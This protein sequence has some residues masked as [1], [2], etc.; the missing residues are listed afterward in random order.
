[1]HPDNKAGAGCGG[2]RARGKRLHS[3]QASPRP[4]SPPSKRSTP[5]PWCGTCGGCSWVPAR[6]GRRRAT[7]SCCLG[8]LGVS[9]GRPGGRGRGPEHHLAAPLFS[10]HRA[11][12][13]VLLSRLLRGLGSRA[14][15]HTA[16]PALGPGPGS[17]APSLPRPGRACPPRAPLTP[18][19][20]PLRFPY[21]CFYFI[22]PSCNKGGGYPGRHPVSPA[23]PLCVLVPA[24]WFQGFHPRGA[25]GV[26]LPSRD[27]T[28]RKG[29]WRVPGLGGPA[30]LSPL[31]PRLFSASPV[32]SELTG[33]G[34][35][36]R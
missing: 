11:R 30:P 10:P 17:L 9:V 19:R 13:W 8:P 31:A 12:G 34:A 29:H 23:P 7:G 25:A 28:G 6:R 2:V 3:A 24:A 32:A 22:V 35:G 14:L 20:P 15:P 5:R 1:M 36:Q 18:L 4:P 21:K 26:P 16:P 27:E 33:A